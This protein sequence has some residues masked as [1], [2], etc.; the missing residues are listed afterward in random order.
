MTKRTWILTALALSSLAGAAWSQSF[1]ASGA[2]FPEPVYKRWFQDY[3]KSHPKVEIN[4]QANG[5][6]SGIKDLINGTVDFAAS[7][8][9]LTKDELTQAKNPIYFPTVLGAVVIAY[10]LPQVKQPL[11]LT[12]D[13]LAGI[14]LT[15]INKWNDPKIA[16]VNPGVTLPNEEIVVVHRSDGSGTTFVF[17][18]YLAK[19]SKEWESGPGVNQNPKWPGG[20]GQPGNQGVAG[21]IKKAKNSIGYVELAYVLDPSN[22]G[23][24]QAAS[25]QNAAGQFVTASVKSVATAGASATDFPVSLSNPPA[26]T[27]DAYPISTFTYMMIPSKWAD[28]SKKAAITDFLKWMLTEGQK[29]APSVFYAPLPAQVVKKDQDQIAKI[30]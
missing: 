22:K 10:N 12:P 21:Q 19:I 4:Y 6:G 24:F 27:K 23:D 26:S 15:K 30:Q 29:T 18:E 1:N 17:T 20:L 16:A 7:D 13:V 3:K 8:R 2:T 28:A 14:F 5:S 25:I 11:K 9:P